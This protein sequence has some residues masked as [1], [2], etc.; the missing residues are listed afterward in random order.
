MLEEAPPHIVGDLH[1]DVTGS[2]LTVDSHDADGVVFASE[3]LADQ[4]PTSV[5]VVGL[6]LGPGLAPDE[7][8]SARFV[9][10]AYFRADAAGSKRK[11]G[12]RGRVRHPDNCQISST[13]TG[14]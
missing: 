4:G 14:Q 11:P 9:G 7:R 3:Q 2:A 6:A 13:P 5:V 8:K 1:R 10:A 12:R